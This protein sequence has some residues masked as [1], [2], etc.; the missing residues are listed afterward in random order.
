MHIEYMS[1]ICNEIVYI[2]THSYFMHCSVYLL[3]LFLCLF[4][5]RHE[6]LIGFYTHTGAHIISLIAFPPIIVSF[7]RLLKHFVRAGLALLDLTQSI[8]A[9]AL[10]ASGA[11]PLSAVGR[12]ACC[13]TFRSISGL[14]A[15][16]A[17]SNPPQMWQ[18]KP[19]MHTPGVPQVWGPSHPTETPARWPSKGSSAP[20]SL[21]VYLV[22]HPATLCPQGGLHEGVRHLYPKIGLLCPVNFRGS[23]YLR[24]HP[25][26]SRFYGAL[27]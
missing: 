11:G 3:Y 15:S 14:H 8:S 27:S 2:F 9:S 25:T 13:D 24:E 16:D 21:H 6:I 19:P 1:Y 22:L 20:L 18:P 17:S 26:T 5:F 7:L 12:P 23:N 10:L 4:I